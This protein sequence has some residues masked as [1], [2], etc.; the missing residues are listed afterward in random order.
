[1]ESYDVASNTW[2]SVAN[3]LENRQNFSAVSIGS[4]GPSEE[5][6]LFDA[7]IVKAYN[8]KT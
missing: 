2:E 4:A 8:R 3:M 6:D 7:P 1:V 5:E